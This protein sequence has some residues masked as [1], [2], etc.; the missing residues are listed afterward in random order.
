MQSFAWYTVK[1]P[2]FTVTSALPGC[3]CQPVAEFGSNVK[4]ATRT[5]VSGVAAKPTPFGIE[6]A[7][8]TSDTTDP[9]APVA[10]ATPMSAID[11][12]MTAATV[13][14]LVRLLTMT[15]PFLHDS[16]GPFR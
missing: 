16:R 6:P 14:H 13:A 8:I 3:V 5:F 4:S 1:V 7:P 9:V 2:D 12:A 15:P 10:T 11:V